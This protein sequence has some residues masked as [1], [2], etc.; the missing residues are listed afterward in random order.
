MSARMVAKRSRKSFVPG[1]R[2]RTRWCV[3]ARGLNKGDTGS[4]ENIDERNYVYVAW[5]VSR[6]VREDRP[7]F[8]SH[9]PVHYAHLEVIP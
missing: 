2:V 6:E 3:G 1:A 7:G 4:V 8:H 5:D 9:E